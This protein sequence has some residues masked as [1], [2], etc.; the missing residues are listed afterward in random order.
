MKQGS[1]D[2]VYA[3]VYLP[4]KIGARFLMILWK[5]SGRKGEIGTHGQVDR[6]TFAG[7]ETMETADALHFLH[8]Q[9]SLDQFS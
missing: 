7:K 6:R 8:T 9:G 5:E 3:L 4:Q 2:R 1:V